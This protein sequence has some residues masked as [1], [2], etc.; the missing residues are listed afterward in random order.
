MSKDATKHASACRNANVLTDRQVDYAISQMVERARNGPN[1]GMVA[2]A[3]H[4]AALAKSHAEEAQRDADKLIKALAKD[5]VRKNQTWRAFGKERSTQF[6][7]D[8]KMDTGYT[9]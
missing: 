2:L 9:A 3:K 1:T 4:F 5:Q 6:I 7:K 8:M